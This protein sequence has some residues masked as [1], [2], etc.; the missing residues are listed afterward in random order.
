MLLLVS[1]SFYSTSQ[2]SNTMTTTEKKVFAKNVL[3]T[4]LKSCCTDPMTGYYR[5]G[6]CDTDHGDY[7]VHVVCAKMTKEFLNFT[8]CNGNDLCTPR[9]EYRFPGLKPGDKWCLCATRWR[10]AMKA[11]VAPPIILESTHAKALEFM[12]LEEMKKYAVESN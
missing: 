2:Q 11:G 4:D 10:D 6:S 3:G 7:G 9:P 5:N 12:T 1:Y 8:L